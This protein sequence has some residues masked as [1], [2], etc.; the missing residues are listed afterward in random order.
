MRF[1]PGRALWWVPVAVAA[2]GGL[3]AADPSNAGSHELIEMEVVGVIPLQSDSA[4]VLV[5]RQKGGA[6]VLPIFVGRS[7]GSAIARR[8][9]G[10]AASRPV[11]SDLMEHAIKALGGKVVR[12]EISGVQAALFRARVTLQQAERRIEVDAR[13]S[14]SVALAMS[15][16][17]PIFAT[18][19]VMADAGLTKEELDRMRSL[20]SHGGEEEGPAS[21]QVVTF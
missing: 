15:S 10:D 6:T 21:G 5:L 11:A 9:K 18:R 4:S 7:E 14:D 19:Q 2:V 16:S 1:S 17:A 13:P 12:V 20:P 8:L 3:A